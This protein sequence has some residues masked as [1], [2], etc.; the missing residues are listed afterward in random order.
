MLPEGKKRKKKTTFPKITNKYVLTQIMFH[1]IVGTISKTLIYRFR[2]K[3][4][5]ID[6]SQKNAPFTP[7]LA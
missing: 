4:K 3:L 5:S 7:F 1:N 2:E 6:L